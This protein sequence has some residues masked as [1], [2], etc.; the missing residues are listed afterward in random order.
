MYNQLLYIIFIV[1]VIFFVL[2]DKNAVQKKH[3]CA[4]QNSLTLLNIIIIT[5]SLIVPSHGLTA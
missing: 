3:T 2:W 4:F 1:H 5:L